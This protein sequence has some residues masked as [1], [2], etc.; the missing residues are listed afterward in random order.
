MKYLTVVS[1]IVLQ[2][3][4]NVLRNRIRHQI[5]H[6]LL[7]YASVGCSSHIFNCT[8]NFFRILDVVFGF[9]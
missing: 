8:D 9:F 4:R 3:A 2:R 5:L 6:F 7:L 1:K